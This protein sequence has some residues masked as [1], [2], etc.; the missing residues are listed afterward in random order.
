M[1][2]ASEDIVGLFHK[3]EDD[4]AR[5]LVWVLVGFT[6]QDN[7]LALHGASGNVNFE[8]LLLLCCSLA[9][10]LLASVLLLEDLTGTLA[11]IAN[12]GL[13][14]HHTRTD[15]TEGLNDTIALAALA[16]RRLGLLFAAR[17]LALA[18]KYLLVRSKLDSLATVKLLER[19]LVLLFLIGT[20]SGSASAAGASRA[21]RASG[22][23][24][25]AKHLGEDVVEV[26]LRTTRTASGLVE[27]GHAVNIVELALLLIAENFVGLRDF[28]EL[29]FGFFSMLFGDLVWVI[30]EGGLFRICKKVLYDLCNRDHIPCGKPS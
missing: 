17:A 18:A 2:N 24:A 19:H 27:G 21:S 9:L 10:A 1:S 6:L 14:A 7:T 13:T 29:G 5:R 22:T 3:G 12:N 16:G 8:N 25:E 23:H 4:I 15:L 11:V 28:L 26:D 20:T 30:L